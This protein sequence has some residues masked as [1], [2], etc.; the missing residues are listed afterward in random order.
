M[1][2]IPNWESDFTYLRIFLLNLFSQLGIS[3]LIH[4]L[5]LVEYPKFSLQLRILF[6][7]PSWI[8]TWHSLSKYHICTCKFSCSNICPLAVF[9]ETSVTH[10]K[11]NCADPD[12][13][14]LKSSLLHFLDKYYK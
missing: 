2:Q 10:E 3:S 5:H 12:S 1:Y 6:Q 13:A 7:L 11:Q 14:Y 9:V 4:K 8:P